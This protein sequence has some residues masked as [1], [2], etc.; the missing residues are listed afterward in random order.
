[1]EARPYQ[2]TAIASTHE[3]FKSFQRQLGVLPTGGG[4]TIVFSHLCK[5]WVDDGSRVLVLAHREELLVQAQDKMRKATGIWAE[6]EKAEH[7]AS[8]NADVVV[9]S[10]QTMKGKRLTR[11]PQDHFDYI[12]I[13][14]AHHA[15]AD[16]YKSL[17]NYFPAAKVLGV[18]ATPD[19]ADKRNLGQ[20]FEN[21]AFEVSLFDLI[22]QGYLSRISVQSVPLQIDLR[23]VKQ[24]SG[25]Y[26]AKQTSDAL[27][28]YMDSIAQSI[29]EDAAFRR[30]LVFLP[31]IAT[32]QKFVEVCKSKGLQAAHVDGESQDRKEILAQYAA[33]EFDV[34]CNAMLLTEGF[35]D[36]G[37][38]C[39]VI[40]RPTRSRSLYSQMV[41]RGTRL[42]PGKP[43]LLLLDFLW[44]HETHNL[45]RPAHLV[46]ACDE[47]AEAI[48]KLAEEKSAGGASQ[49]ELDLEG[50]ASEAQAQ[51][52]EKLRKELEAKTKRKARTIDA[53]EF[54]LSLHATDIAEYEPATNWEEKPVTNGQRDMLAKYGFD[55]DGIK[56]AG[57]ASKIIDLIV[58][59]SKMGLCTPKQM[60]MCK[61]LGHPSA[62]T[63]TFDA[64]SA[65]LDARVGKLKA[66]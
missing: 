16:S 17:L 21:I 47:T 14:E 4:K 9:G 10:V 55:V 15:I 51:R 52:E 50:L 11:W 22:N 25:D 2:A 3:G 54:C 18:T 39:V 7:R 26:D 32:S 60:R 62:E 1:M 57:H 63:L 31:L 65:Y 56:C 29:A 48:T 58:T 8:L 13:D 5:D 59:R 28:P 35:D 24:T 61:Q 30:T 38:D 53:M 34:L 42:S 27:A 12:V 46:S 43:N 66:A 23:G 37:I 6:I 44:L 33:G 40:L 20:F 36:P 41:G 49:E 19:R 45:I 64:A